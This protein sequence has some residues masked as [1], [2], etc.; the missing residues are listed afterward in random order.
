MKDPTPGF[1]FC[2]QISAQ[3]FEEQKVVTSQAA[4]MELLEGIVKDKNLSMKDKKKKLKQFQR[5]Y[6]EIY[7]SR[8]PTTESE[9]RL[10]G[11]K[12]TI[13]QPML[14]LRR[15]KFRNIRY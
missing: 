13:K 7:R 10:F 2:K 5:E 9:A 3:E 14:V 12:P 15:P 4:I 1:Y 6:P 11:D 8:F